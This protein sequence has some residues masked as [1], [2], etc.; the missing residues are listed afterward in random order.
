MSGLSVQ[1]ETSHGGKYTQPTG[2]YVN[3]LHL[4]SGDRYTDADTDFQFHQ[5]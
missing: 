5:Q 4:A 2:L 3:L 1:L